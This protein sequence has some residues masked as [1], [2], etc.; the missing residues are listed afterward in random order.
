MKVIILKEVVKLGHKGEVKD[1]PDGYARNYLIP[2]GFV[3]VLTKHS[4]GQV[5]AQAKK[6]ERGKKKD[7]RSKKGLAKRIN[8]KEFII[9]CNADDKGTLYAGLDEK[10]IIKELKDKKISDFKTNNAGK[11]QSEQFAGKR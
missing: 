9:F 6:K 7:L 2:N 4:F 10:L 5:K 11:K 1:V 3:E 8:N